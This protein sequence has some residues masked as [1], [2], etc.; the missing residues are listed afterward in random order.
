MRGVCLT[1]HAFGKRRECSTGQGGEMA[2]AARLARGSFMLHFPPSFVR[3]RE[4]LVWCRGKYRGQWNGSVSELVRGLPLIL[5]A[6]G[7]FRKVTTAY[8]AEG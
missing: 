1:G 8:S 2:L 3:V 4:T 5:L 6:D 7:L